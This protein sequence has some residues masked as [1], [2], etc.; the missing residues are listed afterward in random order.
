MNVQRDEKYAVGPR[1]TIRRD[2][3][4]PVTYNE[5][6]FCSMTYYTLRKVERAPHDI[7]QGLA[8]GYSCP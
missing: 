1:S 8:E 3:L 6:K 4:F 7:F 2:E 5:G